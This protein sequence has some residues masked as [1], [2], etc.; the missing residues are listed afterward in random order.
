MAAALLHA[1]YGRDR[2][3]AAPFHH[4]YDAIVNMDSSASSSSSS[5]TNSWRDYTSQ[6]IDAI[7]RY[8]VNVAVKELDDVLVTRGSS[9]DL[10][11]TVLCADSDQSNV[12]SGGKRPFVCVCLTAEQRRQPQLYAAVLRSINSICNA[13]PGKRA[14]AARHSSSVVDFLRLQAS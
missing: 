14:R 5:P 2:V 7:V 12:N 9:Y 10:A 11:N 3:Q 4:V 6:Q 13:F 1:Q 8:L